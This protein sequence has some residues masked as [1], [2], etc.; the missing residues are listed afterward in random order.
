MRRL[1]TSWLLAIPLTAPFQAAPAGAFPASSQVRA[2]WHSSEARLLDRHGEL[3]QELRLDPSIRRGDWTPL[4]NV[5]PALTAAVLR[6]ED[7]RFFEHAGVD[8]LAAGK[9]ALGNWL[10][11]RP[12]GASTLTMQLAALLDAR[13]RARGGRRDVAEKWRQMRA[14]RELEKSWP[15]ADMLEAYLNLAPFRGELTG[16]DAAARGLFDKRPDGLSDGESLIL[17]ALI[18][19]PNAKPGEVAKRVCALAAGLPGLGDCAALM[20]LTR[21][22]LSGRYPI[23][24]AA[25]LAPHLAR[26]VML[27]GAAGGTTNPPFSK[28]P[29]RPSSSRREGGGGVFRSS[30]DAGLQR[31][32]VAT[33]REQL[34]HLDGR[35]VRDA[36]ALVLDNASGQV[37]AYA[38]VS[39]RDSI[40]PDSDGVRALRQAGS[41]LK[42]FLYGL[43]LE[44][45]LLTAASPL[46]DAP[47]SISTAV[48][49]YAPRN[50]DHTHRGLVSVRAALAGSLN[51]PAV[52]TLKLVGLEPFAARLA[53]F[54][55]AG[56]GEDADFYGYALALGGL[57]VSLEQ[58]AN[59]Y[60]ALANGGLYTP[61]RF[62]PAS[63]EAA[64][65][66]VQSR[67]SAFLVA[68][69]LS[70]R[71]ARAVTFGL[72]NPLATR[73]WTAVKTGTSK[74]MRDNWCVGFS[75][76]YTVGVWVG[77]FS[78][79]PMH[80]VSGISGAA[81]AWAAI[82]GRL[83]ADLPS[84][85][86]KPPRGLVRK[87][88]R[89]PGEAVRGDWFLPGSE[90]AG[91]T[92]T[93]ASPPA[94]IL[95]P[96]EGMILA[97]D[98][99]I[100]RD[101]QRLGLRAAHVP[102]GAYWLLDDARLDGPEW[103]LAPGRH[104]LILNAPEGRALDQV[105]FEV[106]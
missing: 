12:R 3:L 54:G 1:L 14:A 86:P 74:D 11:A 49:Q 6:A 21:N 48:G 50:Y 78:G 91:D 72:E 20:A 94:E 36:A 87:T 75:S 63:D 42:P 69:I 84:H 64:G 61:L 22:T 40:S 97:L 77:N 79:E 2:A 30:L 71:Q 43:A 56:L 13:Y 18:R 25:N 85:P 103:S 9:A 65:L 59:A 15:K 62:A 100:P 38:S 96:G 51:I 90:P 45:R 70:D 82:M 93:A 57:D 88:I 19:S 7:R 98:P 5:S 89:P 39:N 31:G 68:D 24:P 33:L 102:P 81:P 53:R 17:A 4:A 76:R 16:I 58:L 35:A 26:R 8:W 99:D 104:R 80:D 29:P 46:E 55:F 44:K 95:H 41:T 92:W 101:R 28:T 10:N 32:V 60:R 27:E 83:H 66:R 47:L 37:L 52:Q 34:A 23:V 67:E 73:F 105:S 106:R